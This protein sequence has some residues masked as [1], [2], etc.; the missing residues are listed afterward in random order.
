[1]EVRMQPRGDG[2]QRC[3]TFSLSVSPRCRVFSYRDHLANQVQHF[4]IPGDH[5]QLVIVAHSLVEQQPLG[6]IPNRLTPAA[7]Q[8]LD[9][10]LAQGDFWEMLLPSTFAEPTEPLR[11]LAAEWRIVRHDDPLSM[12]HE[13]SRNVYNNF[14][15]LPRSTKVDS[16]IDV[17]LGARR[18]VCQDFAHIMIALS[19]MV[20]IPCRYV[21]GYLCHGDEPEI[22]SDE[23][24][25]P[26]ATHAWVE[27]FLPRL[28]WVGF[29]PTNDLVAN[30]RHIRTALGRDYADVPPTH[31]VYRG[32]TES[33]L[34][35][36]VHVESSD[37]APP[38]D[39]TMPVPEDW[40]MVVERAHEPLPLASPLLQI[41][42]MQQQQ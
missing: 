19:R 27:A 4:D 2:N 32:K 16:P 1:M 30:D 8:E 36:A 22:G 14:E 33:E 6:P 20:G 13:I 25:A 29:D 26:S 39:E 11:A 17:A 12:L 28:G 31:G 40:S 34:S 37:A 41:Q 21:S 3:L 23:R 7:W 9:V 15:Y 18:G 24:N 10:L 35:V 5:R 38:F 42:Q